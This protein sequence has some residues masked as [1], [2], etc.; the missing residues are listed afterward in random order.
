MTNKI[1][2][3]LLLVLSLT[4]SVHSYASSFKKLNVTATAY[5]SV[6]A[7]TDSSPN[8]AAWGDRLK[9]GMKA[10]AVSRDLLKMGLKRGSKVKISGLPGEYVVLDKMHH[11]WSRKIDIYMGKDVRAAKNWGKRRVTIT[12]VHS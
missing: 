1:I 4:F 8:I 6:R 3:Y 12:V 2:G 10:I 7:Q 11:R 5:N 9:P